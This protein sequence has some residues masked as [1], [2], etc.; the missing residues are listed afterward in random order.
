MTLQALLNDAGH[1]SSYVLAIRVGVALIRLGGVNLVFLI[2]SPKFNPI[3]L[4][5]LNLIPYSESE[6]LSSLRR[7]LDLRDAFSRVFLSLS[8][9]LLNWAKDC[10]ARFG[11]IPA[12]LVAQKSAFTVPSFLYLQQS[13]VL[14]V[15]CMPPCFLH[16]LQC[17]SKR[18][19]LGTCFLAP[20][21]GCLVPVLFFQEALLPDEVL[22]FSCVHMLSIASKEVRSKCMSMGVM[23]SSWRLYWSCHWCGHI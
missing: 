20:V 2:V 5:L 16:R 10:L 4:V 7:F 19:F 12:F 23:P 3:F 22:A 8:N 17:L 9:F 11:F 21:L 15:V 1:T 14:C 13:L 6:L 18:T